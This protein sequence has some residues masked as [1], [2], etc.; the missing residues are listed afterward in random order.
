MSL[1]LP[2]FRP[3]KTRR[4]VDRYRALMQEIM[5]EGRT[6]RKYATHEEENDDDTTLSLNETTLDI[7]PPP[8][9]NKQ[10]QNPT[11]SATAQ[12]TTHQSDSHPTLPSSDNIPPPPPLSQDE[13]SSSN[14]HE[15][16]GD[17][18]TV[19]PPPPL[20]IASSNQERVSQEKLQ[21][22]TSWKD[23]YSQFKS[24][25]QDWK[26]HHVLQDEQLMEHAPSKSPIA[27]I[28]HTDVLQ[29]EEEP[30]DDDNDDLENAG[31]GTKMD[32]QIEEVVVSVERSSD[33]QS[34]VMLDNPPP[35]N[36]V[37]NENDEA[38]TDPLTQSTSV[39]QDQPS[40]QE[41]S[42]EIVPESTNNNDMT[43][44]LETELPS[45]IGSETSEAT[46]EV[47][48]A[49]DSPLSESKGAPLETAEGETTPL[50]IET[51]MRQEGDLNEI[52]SDFESEYDSEDEDD[53]T[54]LSMEEGLA[55]MQSSDEQ[56]GNNN[57]DETVHSSLSYSWLD[58]DD[59]ESVAALDEWLS[60]EDPE[61]YF[62]QV[63]RAKRQGQWTR[64]SL[65]F[66]KLSHSLSAIADASQSDN[67][68]FAANIQREL[69]QQLEFEQSAFHEQQRLAEKDPVELRRRPIPL[70]ADLLNSR[71]TESSFED[72]EDS[73]NDLDL[74]DDQFEML[75]QQLE[76]EPIFEEMESV[77]DSL[78]EEPEE[79]MQITFS[80]Q[81]SSKSWFLEEQKFTLQLLD[82]TENYF[83]RQDEQLLAEAQEIV[84]LAEVTSVPSVRGGAQ[85]LQGLDIPDKHDEDIFHLLAQCVQN[86]LVDED[87]ERIS[88]EIRELQKAFKSMAKAQKTFKGLDGAAH[89]AYQRTHKNDK[90]EVG[91]SGRATRTAAR[92]TAVSSSLGACEL[93][94]LVQKPYL[95]TPSTQ[96]SQSL[97][98]VTERVVLFNETIPL[99]SKK[100]VP[101]NVV[102]F[103]ESNYQ[104]GVG[105]DYGSI[106][107]IS[108]TTTSINRKIN[109]R[110][111]VAVSLPK[112][113][114]SMN[115]VL[116]LLTMPPTHVRLFQG[117]VDEAASVQPALYRA[118]STLLQQL[119]PILREY[120]RSAIHFV[121]HSLGGGVA[122]LASAILDGR[123]PIYGEK[124]KGTKNKSP[125]PNLSNDDA[126][127]EHNPTTTATIEP[128]QGLGRGRTSAVAIGAPPSMSSNV[129]TDFIVSIM[130]GDDFVGRATSESLERFFTR[131]RK[132][133]KKGFLG[134][135]LNRMGDTLSLATSSIKS[136]AHGSEGEE[137]RL[138]IPGRA[139]L[140]RPRRLGGVCSIHEIGNQL[141]GGR[142][143]I[144]ASVLWQLNDILLSKSLWKHHLLESYIQGLDK[145]HL[146]VVESR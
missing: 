11:N 2:F 13:M 54:L 111:L 19:P 114:E 146:R 27:I 137:A 78:D 119:E 48:M 67:E 21:R 85:H 79:P 33:F 86:R 141:K 116:D 35:K 74:S 127:P 84:P 94:E 120:N 68:L 92:T 128:L 4:Q 99:S 43:D 59:D 26:P 30:L 15:E 110:L 112:Q 6:V 103:Y 77:D 115:S 61:F 36:N 108:N 51:P 40:R 5:Q 12:S 52:A 18:T 89:E 38:A 83:T 56:D 29:N 81:K 63:L 88:P 113:S 121:G 55:E 132:A 53:D 98:N 45:S 8:P 80:F 50:S 62:A 42:S 70:I 139:Y 145:V 22:Q 131:T 118:S 138:S 31:I 23:S 58:D 73:D 41:L 76:S 75:L 106:R 17:D 7:P 28:Q 144:R 37:I 102:V 46:D 9:R 122:C 16:T 129:Q 72:G 64:R 142:E 143:A 25:M 97:N 95:N 57:D 3:S 34:D 91:V 90:I 32:E 107:D 104:G 69:Q 125:N 109:G 47:I 1:A 93:I 65:L 66:R 136:Y 101:L 105:V 10:P 130:H 44:D 124:K 135:Q 24:S 96:T 87:N 126:T 134:G 140:I 14:Q 100:S 20:R 60:D 123:L 49:I 133:V 39:S 71:E 82:L 117:R